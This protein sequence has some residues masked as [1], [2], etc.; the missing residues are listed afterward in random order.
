[1]EI[2]FF[3]QYLDTDMSYIISNLEKA[4]GILNVDCVCVICT[5]SFL[6]CIRL[7]QHIQKIISLRECGWSTYAWVGEKETKYG[8]LKLFDDRCGRKT[9]RKNISVACIGRDTNANGL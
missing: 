8:K 3:G 1:M 6:L 2:K 7:H 5:K 9:V 4:K